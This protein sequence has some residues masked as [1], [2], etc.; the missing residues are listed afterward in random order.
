MYQL[1]WHVIDISHNYILNRIDD[2]CIILFDDKQY[3][4][5]NMMFYENLVFTS[6]VCK[7][8]FNQSHLCELFE[9]TIAAKLTKVAKY[10]K[11][12]ISLI[13]NDSNNICNSETAIPIVNIGIFILSGFELLKDN[14]SNTIKY[15][16][17]NITK[18]LEPNET[19][20]EL[21][22]QEYYP[23]MFD[24][25]AD[26]AFIN[27]NGYH[28]NL[29][30]ALYESYIRLK[31]SNTNMYVEL[32]MEEKYYSVVSILDIIENIKDNWSSWQVIWYSSIHK[33]SKAQPFKLYKPIKVSNTISK[34]Y[35]NINENQS[36][37]SVNKLLSKKSILSIKSKEDNELDEL[38]NKT[39]TVS[40]N[41]KEE[42]RK[43]VL[44]KYNKYCGSKHFH[45]INKLKVEKM[46]KQ[47][48]Q[49]ISD[50]LKDIKITKK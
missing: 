34:K 9:E 15:F 5:F 48:L 20:M 32:F 25:L 3:V 17:I 18:G 38:I 16:V 37:L 36:I 24:S 45:Y 33:L 10:D 1:N 29:M 30:K 22:R 35:K 23:E 27:Q 39:K 7:T 28:F 26:E 44:S 47:Q 21:L 14:F 6:N 49:D 41:D 46:K 40:L 19:N 50:M 42:K 8:D 13:Y 43:K 11:V 31:E 4:T 12:F 2:E